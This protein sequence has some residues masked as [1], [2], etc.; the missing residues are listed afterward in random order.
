MRS[1]EVE[2]LADTAQCEK[3]TCGQMRGSGHP[4]GCKKGQRACGGS[5]SADSL[6][7]HNSDSAEGSEQLMTTAVTELA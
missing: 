4:R 3:L 1:R 6:L 5:L 2:L 7:L